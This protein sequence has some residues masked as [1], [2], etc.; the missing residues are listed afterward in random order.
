M[1]NSRDEGNNQESVS[2]NNSLDEKRALSMSPP[3]SSDLSAGKDK[4]ANNVLSPEFSSK[5]ASQRN[6]SPSSSLS[7][8]PHNIS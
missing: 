4:Q 3:E 2:N 8:E 5:R 1:N 6:N 7:P